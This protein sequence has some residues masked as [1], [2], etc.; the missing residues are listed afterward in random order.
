LKI[1]TTS[2][3]QRYEYDKLQKTWQLVD[4]TGIDES[5]KDRVK[6]LFKE[7]ID[8]PAYGI[9]QN[10][11]GEIVE[12]RDTQIT[13]TPNGQLAPVEIKKLFDPDRT[14]RDPLKYYGRL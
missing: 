7:V 4:K 8:N 1:I 3:T 10:P 2:G 11:V 13:F 12:D 5:V 14:K 9:P 6:K